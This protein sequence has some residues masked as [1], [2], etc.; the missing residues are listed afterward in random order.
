MASRRPSHELLDLPIELFLLIFEPLHRINF[1]SDH[2]ESLYY[3]NDSRKAEHK[4]ALKQKKWFADLRL[5]CSTA[6]QVI[7]P[8]AYQEV[9]LWIRETTRLEAMVEMFERNGAHIKSL[10]ICGAVHSSETEQAIGRGLSFCSQLNNLDCYDS[11]HIFTSRRWFAKTA[12]CLA[13]TINSLLLCPARRGSNISHSLIGLGHRIQRLEIIDWYPGP[14]G[15]LFHLP[16]EMPHLTHVVLRGSGGG[17]PHMEN[18]K[19]LFTR[20]VNKH[21]SRS[22][23]V[24]LRSLS[25][26]TLD[27]SGDDIM[28]IL[29]INNLSFQLTTLHLIL[30]AIHGGARPQCPVHIVKACPKLVDFVFSSLRVEKEILNYLPCGLQHLSIFSLQPLFIFLQPTNAISSASDF[31]PFLISG[32]CPDLRTLSVLP[33]SSRA[34]PNQDLLKSTCDSLNITLHIG[35]NNRYW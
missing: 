12:P 31:I 17:R 18:L 15:A 26:V 8:I 2:S 34:E 13:T 14:Q 3:M 10:I 11:K 5:L 9:F 16:S 24:P 21:A 7:T 25:L 27:L 33:W 29:S 23:R 6:N 32:R 30:P 19:K 20:T 35:S 1:R 4:N 22:E 28:T